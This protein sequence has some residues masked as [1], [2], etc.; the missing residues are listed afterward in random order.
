MDLRRPFEHACQN[1][2]GTL[3]DWN[4]PEGRGG[5]YEWAV[6]KKRPEHGRVVYGP[7]NE[8]ESGKV[9]RNA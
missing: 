2:S 4:L 1:S 7:P 6:D 5:V 8:V 3:E 9:R